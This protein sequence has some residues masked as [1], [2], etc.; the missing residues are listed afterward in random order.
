MGWMQ[1]VARGL[2]ATFGVGKITTPLRAQFQ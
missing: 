1:R 2:I